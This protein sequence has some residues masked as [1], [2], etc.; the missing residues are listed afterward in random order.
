MSDILK[1]AVVQLVFCIISS[2]IR[3]IIEACG[4]TTSVLYCIFRNGPIIITFESYLA[5][6]L[7]LLKFFFRVTRK[8]SFTRDKQH[9]VRHFVCFDYKLNLENEQF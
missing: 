2:E 7:F 6:I 3:H 9:F 5:F 1:P 8:S 4:G